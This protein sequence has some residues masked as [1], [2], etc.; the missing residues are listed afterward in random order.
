MT[1]HE[2]RRA[3]GLRRVAVQALVEVRGVDGT[4][5]AFEAESLD[6]SQR[7]M[8]LSTAYLPEIGAPVLCRFESSGREIVV[9]G[10][11]AWSTERSRGGDFGIRFTR[12]DPQSCDAL[13]ELC[14]LDPSVV[15]GAGP[16]CQD[17]IPGR[18]SSVAPGSRVMLHIDGLSAPMRARVDADRDGRIRV[19][20]SLEFLRLGRTLDL[21]SVADGMRLQAR[22]HGLDVEIDPTTG[23]PR[24]MVVLHTDQA[25]HDPEGD[26][27]DMGSEDA[28]A[29]QNA[30]E[31]AMHAV[32][33]GARGAMRTAGQSLHSTGVMAMSGVGS[34]LGA[35]V[36]R[37]VRAARRRPSEEPLRR[38]TSPP[39][40]SA[41]TVASRLP[42]TG[43]RTSRG[44][45]EA[46][47]EFRPQRRALR[48]GGTVVAGIL[49]LVVVALASQKS[50]K[51]AGLVA[52]P[53]QATDAAVL[54][55]A[56]SPSDASAVPGGDSMRGAAGTLVPTARVPLF[57][58][59][60]MTALEPAPAASVAATI[61]TANSVV[62]REMALAKMAS[63]ESVQAAVSE[64]TAAS[65]EPGEV[66][67]Q[68]V[69]K[70]EDVPPW[71]RGR[72]REPTVYR[73][74]L[75]APGEAIR[76]SATAKG[77][78]VT[79]PGRKSL[80]SPKAFAKRDPRIVKVSAANGGDGAKF[81][82]QFSGEAPSYR[83]RLRRDSVEFLI[84]AQ[85]TAAATPASAS[86]SATSRRGAVTPTGARGGVTAPTASRR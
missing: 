81:V 19:G 74:K 60:P 15:A 80:E 22:I 41:A 3:E 42:R 32:V 31:R 14:G 33:D 76:G 48:V 16:D 78:S 20:S 39:P 50:T 5:P 68:P 44:A 40:K 64:D 36:S 79:V 52:S 58:N 71:G 86:T 2:E 67:D 45:D 47:P 53:A 4:V 57:G 69:V 62:A 84:G 30:R 49:V 17:E 28:S 23:V 27:A 43:N 12:L 65:N 26:A 24:L 55:L 51:P 63:N 66:A 7:G 54:A 73:I 46:L 11:V 18:A 85:G 59:T 10:E 8:H 35:M 72:M 56:A 70:P 29:T 21:E 83:V 1:V 34:M 61:A 9:E 77:F 13:S 38:R 6:V 25:Q 37:V 75:D 82:W